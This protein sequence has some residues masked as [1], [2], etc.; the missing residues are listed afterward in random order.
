MSVS[1]SGKTT[2]RQALAQ[3]LTWD[4]FDIDKIE[5]NIL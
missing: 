1:S 2:L 3:K 5:A 4:F